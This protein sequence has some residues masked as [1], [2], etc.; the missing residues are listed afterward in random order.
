LIKIKKLNSANIN[1]CF[2]LID[3]NHE[4]KFYFNSL[5]WSKHQILA[6]FKKKS[7]YSLGLFKND[8]IQAFVIGELIYIEKVSEYEILFIYVSK[9]SRKKSYATKLL[10]Y[11]YNK[12]NYLKL[13][14][15]YLEV[16]ENNFPAIEMYKKNKFKMY[17]TRKNYY[18]INNN[19][20]HAL[21]YKKS[22]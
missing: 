20:V 19:K 3:L 17:Y 5:G 1:D 8:K 7:N 11:I 21:C 12:K 10:N 15:I 2:D 6:Q 16:A 9:N 14:K 13:N 22:L 4:D 18:V